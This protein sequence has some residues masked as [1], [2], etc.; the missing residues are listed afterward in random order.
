MFFYIRS[1]IDLVYGV[2]GGF[3]LLCSLREIRKSKS[4]PTEQK[5]SIYQCCV[6]AL[7]LIAGPWIY[8]VAFQLTDVFVTRSFVFDPECTRPIGDALCSALKGGLMAGAGMLAH[9]FAPC[10]GSVGG[11]LV[12]GIIGE[13]IALFVL[14]L[15]CG[16]SIVLILQL[17]Y[18]LIAAIVQS[19]MFTL[20]IITGP[21]VFACGGTNRLQKFSAGYVTVWIDLFL[22]LASSVALMTAL[23]YVLFSDLN[24][25]FKI[26]LSMCNL[27]AII[28]APLALSYLSI[29]PVSRYLRLNPIQ[30]LAAGITQLAKLASEMFACFSTPR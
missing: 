11:G 23:R 20:S 7:I 3:L 27:Q 6:I 8:R 21:I 16:L 12:T 26:M 5:A 17:V 28:F 10:V 15:Y 19:F 4:S 22:W 29:S 18:V 2:A 25:W 9:L 1:A 14:I 13:V 24:P 30:G